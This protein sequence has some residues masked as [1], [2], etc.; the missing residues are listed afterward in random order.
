MRLNRSDIAC[1]GV[2]FILTLSLFP[3]GAFTPSNLLVSK[4]SDVITQ[5]LPHQIFTRQSL[6]QNKRF[7][8]WNPYECAGTPAF[9]NPLYLTFAF[10]HLLLIPLPPP[11][12]MNIGFF[13]HIFL[14]GA[15]TYAYARNIGCAPF[16]SLFAALVFSLGARSLS[17]VQGGIYPTVAYLPYVP[18]LFLSAERCISRPSLRA[19]LFMAGC[20]TLALLT[21]EMQMLLYSSLFVILY[22]LLRLRTTPDQ[23]NAVALPARA[24]CL[25]LA[26]MF[27]CVPLSAL[28]ILPAWHLYP[29][30]TRSWPLGEAQFSLMPGFS[31]LRLLLNPRLLS[32]FTPSTELPWESVLYIGLAPLVIIAWMLFQ[33]SSKRDTCLWGT[34]AAVALA[35]SIHELKPL[36]IVLNM[37]IPSLKLFRNPGRM[38]FF[39]PFF[40]AVL[41]ARGLRL[42]SSKESPGR[43]CHAARFWLCTLIIAAIILCGVC[44]ATSR[45]DITSLMDQY[46]QRFSSFFGSQYLALIDMKALREEASAFKMGT[47]NSFVFQFMILAVLSILFVLRDLRKMTPPLFSILLLAVTYADLFYFG[48]QYLELHPI[49]EIY[50]PSILCLTLERAKQPSRLLDSTAPPPAPFWTAFPFAQ[51]TARGMPRID[52]YTPVNLKSYVRYLDLLRGRSKTSWPRWGTTVPSVDCPALLSL[53]NT[54]FLISESP[55]VARPFALSEEFRNV[56]AYKQFLGARVLPRLFLYRNTAP[57]P[58]AWLVPEAEICGS[59]EEDQRLISLDFR[60]NALLPPGARPLTGGEPYRAVPISR[61]ASDLITI[62]LDTRRPSYLCLSE[63][64]APGWTATDN[65]APV[66]VARVNTAFRGIYLDPGKHSLRMSYRPPGMT[67]GV[68]VSAATGILAVIALVARQMR[69]DLHRGHQ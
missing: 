26:G 20:M 28:Y 54:G 22:S 64:W 68:V 42:F 53:L 7:P 33:D 24:F 55:R 11:L 13:L 10:P 18:L 30:L 14:A 31:S 44:A 16:A 5:H 12:A 17:Q 37:F 35:F 9:P 27:L 61:Y 59:S 38:L 48:K 51:S 50:P 63:I 32:D 41:G 25:L 1:V 66:E 3:P 65:G 52:G 56:P 23:M 19:S 69:S 29:L 62:E 46:R 39:L 36:H 58:S 60:Q 45:E 40:A 43:S 21:G 6:L 67:A 4:Y 15:L 57:L 47:L 34:L 49:E 8:V 2:L